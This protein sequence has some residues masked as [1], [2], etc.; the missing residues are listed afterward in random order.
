LKPSALLKSLIVI[1]FNGMF[2]GMY[3]DFPFLMVSVEAK[4]L[5]LLGDDAGAHDPLEAGLP[6]GD[7]I[8]ELLQV[9]LELAF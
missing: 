9:R 3:L 6:F 5:F 1:V 4:L 2:P 8:L 7:L